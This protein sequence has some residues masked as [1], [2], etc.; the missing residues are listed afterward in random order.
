MVQ[1]PFWLTALHDPDLIPS[2]QGIGRHS[3]KNG[4]SLVDVCN[5]LVRPPG[6]TAL[7]FDLRC[8]VEGKGVKYKLYDGGESMV[9]ICIVLFHPR[10]YP[11]IA[12]T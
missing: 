6:V 5:G 3:H 2:W 11:P 8:L 12:A 10:S 7:G 9:C 1:S 4:T